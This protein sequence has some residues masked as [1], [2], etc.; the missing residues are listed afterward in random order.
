MMG[1]LRECTKEEHDAFIASYPR[2]LTRDLLTISQP[3]QLQHNDFT[4]GN[5]P[6]SVVSSYETWGH[7]PGDIYGKDP[8]NWRILEEVPHDAG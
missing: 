2:K 7:T 4:L 3:E 8:G 5:W 1:G 6:A